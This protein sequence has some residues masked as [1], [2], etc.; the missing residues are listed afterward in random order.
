ME[1]GLFDVQ[2]QG[3]QLVAMLCDARPGMQIADI[4]SGAGGKALVMAAAMSNKGRILAI[5]NNADR[6]DK[7][8]ARLR[9]AGIHNVERKH[10]A[11]KWSNRPWRG[12]FDRVVVDAPCSGSGTWR[13]QVDARWRLTSDMLTERQQTQAI[14]LDKARAMVAPGGRIVYITCSVLASEGRDQIKRLL[15]MATELELADIVG[16][17]E[18]H[19]QGC[20][21]RGAP[22]RLVIC[23]SYCRGVTGVMGFSWLFFRPDCDRT[24][25]DKAKC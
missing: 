5:D 24:D 15:A 6:L 12:K 18:R 10:V 21:W 14:L 13:R 20:W 1:K 2:D 19:G 25:V 4:C 23:S 7:A 17:M 8:G 11:D 16:G 22:Q 3:S 9:R